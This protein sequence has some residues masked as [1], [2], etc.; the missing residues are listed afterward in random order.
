MFFYRDNNENHGRTYTFLDSGG[1]T[2]TDMV[3][4]SISLIKKIQ[5]SMH[6]HPT[7]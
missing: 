5:S 4:E 7:K 2:Q 3:K 1:Q 6:G